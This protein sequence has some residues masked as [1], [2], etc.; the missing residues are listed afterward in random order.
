MFYVNTTTK[1]FTAGPFPGPQ[2]MPPPQS[3]GQV[4]S[5]L[6]T[7]TPPRAA[8]IKPTLT[9]YQNV[10][11][12]FMLR[13]QKGLPYDVRNATFTLAVDNNFSH[14]DSLICLS[15]DFTVAYAEQGIIQVSA[16]CTSQKF[17][18]VL[19]NKIPASQ[20]WMQLT[21]YTAQNIDGTVL[22]QDN[23][24]L[25]KPKLYTNQGA[26]APNDPQYYNKAQID[27]LIRDIDPHGNV[28]SGHGAPSDSLG[29]VGDLYVDLDDK[30]Y[31]IK[32]DDGWN[33]LGYLMEN[34]SGLFYQVI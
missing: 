10:K 5:F 27:R 30:A 34:T 2:P 15:S 16:V 18:K 12:K 19:K 29:V 9:Q 1:R 14:S 32:T 24:I 28:D 3:C 22:L 21:A 33:L 20:V 6:R 7:R 26:P 4:P 8:I 17:Q 23:G 11:L 25:L 31:W 13:D